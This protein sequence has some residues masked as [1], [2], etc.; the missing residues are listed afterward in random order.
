M[1]LPVLSLITILF[2]QAP[3][4]QNTAPQPDLSATIEAC[5]PVMDSLFNRE[6]YEYLDSEPE[7]PGGTVMFYRYLQKNLNGIQTGQYQ[8]HSEVAFIVET[9]GT[10]KDVKI[11]KPYLRKGLTIL[12]KDAIQLVKRMP[13]WKPAICDGNPVPSKFIVP[14]QVELRDKDPY[15]AKH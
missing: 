10:I 13:A 2:F 12:E 7:F 4:I 1:F 14:I 8:T 3:S 11:V 5:K 9:D 6:I 15:E